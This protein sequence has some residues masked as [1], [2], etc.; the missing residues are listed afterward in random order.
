[1]TAVSSGNSAQPINPVAAIAKALAARSL[2]GELDG[3]GP[4]ARLAAAE[5]AMSALSSRRSGS[6]SMAV[7]TITGPDGRRRM[8]LAIVNPNM[9]FLVDSL[10]A[11][12]NRQELGVHLVIH[13]IM[14][15]VRDAKGQLTAIGDEAG[16]PESIMQRSGFEREMARE[17][18]DTPA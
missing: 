3:F 8:R 6:P 12:L 16:K 13:P 5:F 4:Q 15:V 17:A 1:M 7:D 18:P 2:P 9:P 10:T 11:E 14:R